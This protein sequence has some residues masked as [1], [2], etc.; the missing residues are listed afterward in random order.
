MEDRRIERNEGGLGIVLAIILTALI[1]G[2]GVFWWQ[3]ARSTP[4]S[5]QNPTNIKV[6]IPNPLQG[7]NNNSYPDS[8]SPSDNTQTP[9][10]DTNNNSTP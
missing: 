3:S 4:P 8:G 9:S 5:D 6:E 1:I 7:N 10:T 2:G